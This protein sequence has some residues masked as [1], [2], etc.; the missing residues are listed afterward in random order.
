MSIQVIEVEDDSP[1]IGSPISGDLM[2]VIDNRDNR[3]T[4]ILDW[5]GE[6]TQ[7]SHKIVHD[8]QG[9]QIWFF[10]ARDR[11]NFHNTWISE[12]TD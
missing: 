5:I 11:T 12:K 7:K 3:L 4:M 9:V 6:N 8:G 10:D 1:Y 2:Y